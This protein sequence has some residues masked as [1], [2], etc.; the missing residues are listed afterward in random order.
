MVMK[1][2]SSAY[3]KEVFFLAPRLGEMGTQACL[4]LTRLQ[5]PEDRV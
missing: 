2:I 4:I 1:K 5:T 3:C